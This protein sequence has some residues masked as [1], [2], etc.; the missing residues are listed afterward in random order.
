MFVIKGVSRGK[1]GASTASRLWTSDVENI[2]LRHIQFTWMLLPL[3]I[4]HVGLTMKYF[5]PDWRKSFARITNDRGTRVHLLRFIQNVTAWF[6]V[7]FTLILIVSGL[8]ALNG[9]Q[10]NVTGNALFSWHLVLD[11]FLVISIIIHTGIGVRFVM[12]RRRITGRFADSLVLAIC[13]LALSGTII[14]V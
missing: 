14:L 1:S 12:M 9:T 2:T 13:I 8:P 10:G 5:R 3:F 11:V 6:I 7:L 4:L